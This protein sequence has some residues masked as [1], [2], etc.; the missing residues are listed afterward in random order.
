M[1]LRR[2]PI[3]L[4]LQKL[5]ILTENLEQMYSKPILFWKDESKKMWHWKL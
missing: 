2:H 1:S 4:Q 3:V 5:S